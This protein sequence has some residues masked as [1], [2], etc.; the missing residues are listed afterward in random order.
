MRLRHG[1]TVVGVSHTVYW[2]HWIIVATV[3]N[4]LQCIVFML[5]G[6]AFQFEL[7]QNCEFHILWKIQ[8]WMG[9][10]MI[11]LA[12]LLST[13]VQSQDKAN[14]VAYSLLLFI[15]V[16]DI[17]FSNSDLVLGLFYTSR[18]IEAGTRYIADILQWFPSFSY[19]MMFGLVANRASKRF[20][21]QA[22]GWYSGSKYTD[23]EWVQRKEYYIDTT[24]TAIVSPSAADMFSKLIGSMFAIT[25]LWWY[26][27]HVIASNRGAA[28][29]V[30]FP[31]QRSYWASLLP[32]ACAKK[33]DRARGKQKSKKKQITNEDLGII[34]QDQAFNSAEREKQKVKENDD[35]DIRADGIR[36]YNL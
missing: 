32:R 6:Y 10:T 20:S 7:F 14:Q 28:Y 36:M 12:F 29:S 25:L 16:M 11:L 18:S 3:V 2:M 1:L 35:N 8:F 34:D 24:Q 15:V 27:D 21:Y 17:V 13:M 4:T 33:F 5:S 9:Q 19:A 26:L 30:F 23:K 22:L 31:F